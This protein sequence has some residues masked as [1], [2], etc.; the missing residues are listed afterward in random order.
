MRTPALLA[1]TSETRELD[2]P[3]RSKVPLNGLECVSNKAGVKLK[4]FRGGVE[5]DF[6]FTLTSIHI[7][8]PKFCLHV[9]E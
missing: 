4:L 1:R 8:E 7:P 5:C 6:H 9:Q 3:S 2:L